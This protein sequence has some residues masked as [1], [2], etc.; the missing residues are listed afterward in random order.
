MNKFILQLYLCRE[1]ELNMFIVMRFAQI[2]LKEIATNMNT[3]QRSIF[4]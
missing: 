3:M 1:S 4:Y 2:H